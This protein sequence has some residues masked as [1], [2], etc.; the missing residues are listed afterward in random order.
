MRGLPVRF[1]ASRRL[2]AL[3]LLLG[4]ASGT[5]A[6]EPAG[7]LGDVA[8][9][10]PELSVFLSALQAMGLAATLTGSSYTAFAPTNDAFARSGMNMKT[11]LYAENAGRLLK[12][13]QAHIVADD[14]NMEMAL[15]LGQARTLDGGNID[16]YME[17]DSL[18]VDDAMV[19]RSGIT[20][21]GLRIYVIDQVLTAN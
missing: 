18:M 9:Q 21:G 17:G 14:I 15:G 7:P 5:G 6:A 4:L 10:E 11:L 19:L 12:L 16:L 20:S 13:L 3:L 2:V 8:R 1:V